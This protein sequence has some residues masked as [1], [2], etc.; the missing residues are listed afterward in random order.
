VVKQSGSQEDM[1]N[2]ELSSVNI[3]H[4]NLLK[5]TSRTFY[6]SIKQLPGAL[7]EGIC[8]AYLL[9]R[10]SDFFEDNIYMDPTQKVEWLEQWQAVLEG[11]PLPEEWPHRLGEYAIDDAEALAAYSAG[12]ILQK[13][14][15]LPPHL[16]EI[17]LTHV[18]D[19]TKGMIR[20][21]SQ[22]PRVPGEEEMDDYMH[23]VAGRVGYLLTEAFAWHS[24][25]IKGNMTELMKF[26]RETGLALQTVNI[27][28]GLHKDYERGWIFVPE[29]FCHEVGLGSREEMFYPEN[30]ELAMRVVDMLADKADRHL[31]EALQYIKSLPVMHH[32]IRLFIIWPVFIA[33]RTVAISRSNRQALQGQAKVKRSEIKG[34]IRTTMLLGWSNAFLDRYFQQMYVIS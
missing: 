33:A 34:I 24:K 12:K 28:R 4:W 15:Q 11:E 14:K 9:L 26:A 3:D 10:V 18:R 22:G 21:M 2:S 19:T 17:L 32:R 8:L 16:R 6:P 1:I 13:C 29:S 20:W 5:L 23:E 7:R 30:H 27:L 25:A 31:A